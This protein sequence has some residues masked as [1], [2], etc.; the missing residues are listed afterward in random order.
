MWGDEPRLTIF[1]HLDQWWV[2]YKVNDLDIGRDEYIFDTLDEMI[3]WVENMYP[4]LEEERIE[5][6]EQN[7]QAT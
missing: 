4:Q 3:N 2:Y 5:R 6:D 7:K 1:H